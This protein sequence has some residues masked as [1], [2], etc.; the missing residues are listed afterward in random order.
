[1]LDTRAWVFESFSVGRLMVLGQDKYFA[2]AV[3]FF[4]GNQVVKEILYVE[5][6]AVLESVVGIPEYAKKECRAAYITVGSY[7]TLSTVVLFNIRFDKHGH[8]IK[9]WDLP[10]HALTRNAV[11]GPD[12]GQGNI[13]LVTQKTCENEYKNSLWDAGKHEL[14]VLTSIRDS[15][16][17]NKLGLYDGGDR[18]RYGVN[19]HH[20]G[21]PSLDTGDDIGQLFSDDFHQELIK[22]IEATLSFKYESKIKQLHKQRDEIVRQL[23]GQIDA[24]KRQNIELQQSLDSIKL[25]NKQHVDLIAE[26]YKAKQEKALAAMSDSF[27]EQLGAKE[28]ELSYCQENERQL[29][30]EMQQL[31]E[32]VEEEKQA[33]LLAFQLDLINSGVE[34]IV[35]QA[36]VGSYSLKLDQ[37]SRYIESPTEFWAKRCGVSEAKY[38]AWYQHYKDPVCH[39][40]KSTGC[41]CNVVIDR[42]DNPK[43]FVTGYSEMCKTHQLKQSKDAMSSY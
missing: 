37:I 10:L 33:D 6:Q 7:L 19:A 2:E 12:L 25:Q 8:V 27:T 36:G 38:L 18:R 39:A 32:S 30:E 5:F 21:V 22:N 16:K 3:F 24:V 42:V 43:E 40:G 28:L 9:E 14:A 15:V 34:L 26:K 13:L 20:R 23:E 4:E 35:T 29:Q 17:R 41:S 1:M 11:A 31:K